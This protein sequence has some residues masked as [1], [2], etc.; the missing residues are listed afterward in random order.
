MK[1]LKNIATIALLLLIAA[2]MIFASIDVRLYVA[3]GFFFLA[4]FALLAAVIYSLIKEP[5]KSVKTLI[6]VAVMV[7]LILVFYFITPRNDVALSLYEKTG[8][9]LSWSPIIGAGLYTIYA[10]L[11]IF[12]ALL[13]FFGLK[14]ILKP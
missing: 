7:A 9:S 2:I 5:K 8:T 13:A 10:F 14:N 3:Y 4:I 12:V 11:A 6:V 1:L